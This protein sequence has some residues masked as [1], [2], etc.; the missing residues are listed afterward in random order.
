[1]ELEQEFT[2]RAFL[3][4]FSI[5]SAQIAK[6]WV[7]NEVMNGNNML[8]SILQLE[9]TEYGMKKAQEILQTCANTKDISLFNTAYEEAWQRVAEVLP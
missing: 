5:L 3:H 2:Q 7:D 4:K 1:M 6:S 9:G 8:L